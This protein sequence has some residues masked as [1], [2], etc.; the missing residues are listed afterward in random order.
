MWYNSRV[1][2]ACQAL[3]TPDAVTGRDLMS[4]VASILNVG[5]T[6]LLTARQAPAGSSRLKTQ[7]HKGNAMNRSP[8]HSVMLHN[9]SY[10][11]VASASGRQF[12]NSI[13]FMVITALSGLIR[14]DRQLHPEGDLNSPEGGI[15]A[16][17]ALMSGQ[18]DANQEDEAHRDMGL[19][20]GLTT[21]ER[22]RYLKALRGYA[23][24]RL[25][26]HASKVQFELSRV[27]AP[28][29]FE[30]GD[31]I[32]NT[33]KRQID[34]GPREMTTAMKM[35][36]RALGI[37]EDA[38]L[39]GLVRQQAQNAA[40]LTLNRHHILDIYA[41]LEADSLDETAAESIWDKLPVMDRFRLFGACDSGLY[42]AAVNQGA[43]FI[44]FKVQEGKDNVVII[45]AT[46]HELRKDINDFLLD[47]KNKREIADAMSAG[48]TPPVLQP[49]PPTEAEL[50]KMSTK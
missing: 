48:A 36:A 22:C 3:R 13:N 15:D 8:L 1:W 42:F 2:R 7:L 14:Q 40:F 41:K 39:A 11:I 49:L 46:R 18:D 4:L 37:P 9:P 29:P 30:V 38:I 35:E 12:V 23:N 16:Y 19:G 31:P 24:D 20:T 10:P 32:E 50:K 45:N 21:L 28:N 33:M 44:N 6:K 17:N 26:E 5:Q 47:P 34:R 27:V 43:R 25:M